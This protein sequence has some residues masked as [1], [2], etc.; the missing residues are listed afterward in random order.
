MKTLIVL[1]GPTAVGKTELALELAEK[2]G[3]PIINCDS[4]QIYKGMKIGTAAPTEDQLKRVKHYFVGTLE[5]DDYYSAAR[6]EEEVLKLTSE[7]FKTHDMLILSGGSMMYIDAVCNG[8]DYIPNV[9]EKVRE[10]LKA[11][12][13]KEGL[14]QLLE[15]L[16]MHDPKCYGQID[17]KNHKRVIHAL[18]IYY[19]TGKPYS[20]FL[21]RN[22]LRNGEEREESR[23][24]TENR[25]R[26]F[27]IIKIGLQRP[28]EELFDRINRRVD[29]MMRDGLYEEALSLIGKRNL[30]ALNTVGYKEMFKVIDGEWPMDMAV[31]RIKKNTR[32]Y[33][34]K[35]MTWFMHDKTIRWQP[36]LTPPKG[37]EQFDVKEMLDYINKEIR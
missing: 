22:A 6:Y 37:G 26:P 28:R 2:L 15:E 29:Q 32:V 10:T 23:E 19:T 11:R 34:K 8:I 36:P 12:Y 14:D 30:N 5:L 33:A 4:R 16:K 3:S 20:S 21:T 9:D 24:G 18:E 31:E 13:E 35:Q 25:V 17:R 1:L 27:R 7:L